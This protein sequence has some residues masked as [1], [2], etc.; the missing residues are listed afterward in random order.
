MEKKE[1]FLRKK[2]IQT[3]LTIDSKKLNQ[4]KTGNVSNRW[5]NGMLI[6][7]SGVDYKK[8]N[9]TDI[10][11]VDIN[12]K[13][14]GEGVPSIEWRFHLNI[15]KKRKEIDSII[16]NHPIYGTGFSI[17]RKEIKSFHYLIGLFGG[18]NIKCT[19][20]KMPG[21]EELSDEVFKSLKNRK[22]CLIANHGAITL[23]KDLDEAL[24]L[25][26]QFE[27]LCQQITIANINGNPKFIDH[28]EMKII[29][30]KLKH[31]NKK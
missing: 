24:Y 15:I 1:K 6:T 9:Y 13:I 20:F 18:A 3:C 8:L 25:A 14:I 4:G 12:G 19:K 5:K 22:A 21:T 17:L 26:E 11:F 7:P 30:K 28:K 29:I 16:H 27:A 31:Y 10:V 2:I 23:G